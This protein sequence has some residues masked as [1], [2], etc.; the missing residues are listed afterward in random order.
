LARW[1]KAELPRIRTANGIDRRSL[2][3]PEGSTD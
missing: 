1:M 2:L 3:I